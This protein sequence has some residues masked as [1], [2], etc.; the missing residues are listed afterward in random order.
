MSRPLRI[1]HAGALYH[2]TSRGNVRQPI[3]LDV[4]DFALFI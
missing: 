3:Y 4:Q 2:V 1:E